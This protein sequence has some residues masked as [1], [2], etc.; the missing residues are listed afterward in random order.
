[1][2]AFLL[3]SF[4][5]AGCSGGMVWGICCALDDFC[6]GCSHQ[7]QSIVYL[8]ETKEG[9]DKRKISNKIRNNKFNLDWNCSDMI[10][11]N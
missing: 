4:S 3:R 6:Q 5:G 10:F 7:N 1:M 8:P 11:L 9:N 2:E